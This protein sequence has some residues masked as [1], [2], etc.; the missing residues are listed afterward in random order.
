[1]SCLPVQASPSRRPTRLPG[2]RMEPS[3]NRKGPSLTGRG[4]GLP[5]FAGVQSG[6]EGASRIWPMGQHIGVR[7]SVSGMAQGVSFQSRRSS[8]RG[9]NG[10]C[11]GWFFMCVVFVDGGGAEVQMP[12]PGLRSAQCIRTSPISTKTTPPPQKKVTTPDVGPGRAK[13]TY[14]T[15]QYHSTAQ[16]TKVGRVGAM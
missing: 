9:S 16:S 10:H 13:Y 14:G 5:Y 3:R 8:T 4:G 15:I 7:E 11:R 1:M 2:E 6:L 12:G